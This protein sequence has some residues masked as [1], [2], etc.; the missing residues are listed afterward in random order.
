MDHAKIFIKQM[1]NDQEKN[2]PDFYENIVIRV[3]QKYAAMINVLGSILKFPTSTAFTDLLTKHLFDMAV[4]MDEK[5][6]KKLMDDAISYIEKQGFDGGSAPKND[7]V[8]TVDQLVSEAYAEKTSAL[9]KF[10]LK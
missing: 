3:D 9:F 7:E 2:N 1:K 5:K 10:D 6:Y 8:N 4:T